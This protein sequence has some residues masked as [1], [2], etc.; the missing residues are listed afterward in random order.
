MIKTRFKFEFQ[1]S[2]AKN[3]DPKR[4]TETFIFYIEN[5]HENLKW[6]NPGSA[7]PALRRDFPFRCSVLSLP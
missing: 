5:H 4:P 6:L 7:K 1:H 2:T 3:F